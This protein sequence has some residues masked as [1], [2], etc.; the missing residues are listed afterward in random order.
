[1]KIAIVLPPGFKFDVKAPNSIETVVRTL[2]D[3]GD[4]GHS[5]RVFCDESPADHG[6]MPVTLIPTGRKRT[7]AMIAALKAFG[8]DY[9]EFQQNAVRARPIAKAF[10]N[11]P[12]SL[13]R[14]NYVKHQHSW[15]GR[16][17]T[18]WYNRPYKAFIFVSQA[19]LDDFAAHNPDQ[20]QRSYKVGNPIDAT[21]WLAPVEGKSPVIAFC[22]RAAPEKGLAPFCEAL[23]Q[24]LEVRPAWRGLLLLSQIHVHPAFI[25]TQLGRL[26]PF[27][28]RVSILHDLP[29][30]SVMAEMR[31]AAIAVIPS[32]WQEPFGLTA[33]EAH[34]SGVC[35]ISSGSGGLREASGD[36]ALFVPEVTA[37]HLTEAMLHLIDNEPLRLRMARQGQAFV[38]EAHTPVRRAIELDAIRRQIAQT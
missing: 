25:E 13:Y 2:H 29:L 33:L 31:Q 15:T 23:A 32:L 35:V 10:P 19:A 36:H 9:I 17:K 14:H 11:T 30:A 8:P 16:L 21:P 37:A 20:A 24:V 18:W 28:E 3:G 1:M 27:G 34:A 5:V 26:A 12:N 38:K 4:F 6:D 7:K 22:G